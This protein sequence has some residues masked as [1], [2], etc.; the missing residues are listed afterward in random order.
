MPTTATPSAG[1]S[2][3]RNPFFA[4]IYDHVLARGSHRKDIGCRRELLDGLFGTMVEVGPGNGPNFGLYP[5][6]VMRVIA[7]EPEPYLRA[8]A[9]QAASRA[10]VSVEVVDGDAD[11]LPVE[12]ASVDAVVL[13]L[14]LCSVPDQAS[15]LA[16]ARRVLRPGGELRIYEHVIAERPVPRALQKAAQA[17]FWPRAFGNC[18]PARDTLAALQAAGF[19]TAGVRRFVMQVAAVEPPMPY[20]L[21]RIPT[22]TESRPI[23]DQPPV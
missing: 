21:G 16:E 17:T 9:A 13:A 4:R 20:I 23:S 18:H 14:V 10:P 12:D 6:T 5:T 19:D 2:D 1:E 15:A 22:S 11:H 7:V 3:I 8:R